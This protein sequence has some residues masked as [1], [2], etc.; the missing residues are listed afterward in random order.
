MLYLAKRGFENIAIACHDHLALEKWL[1]ENLNAQIEE[2]A[3]ISTH[4]SHNHSM[5]YLK[6]AAGFKKILVPHSAGFILSK[7]FSA[8]DLPAIE[9]VKVLPQ[10][11]F[12]NM[13]NTG[14]DTEAVINKVASEL[15]AQK[16]AIADAYEISEREGALVVFLNDSKNGQ[17]ITASNDLL[18]V[19]DNYAE[20]LSYLK[21]HA[22]RY[23]AK[24]Y[25]FDA[26]HIVE[27][28]IFDE[29]EKYSAQYR[30]FLQAM[31][32]LNLGYI[33]SEYWDREVER[34]SLPV[35]AYR[36]RILTFMEPMDFKILLTAL[37]YDLNGSR[38]VDLD[39]FY[40]QKKISWRDVINT[41]EYRKQI[42]GS[43]NQIFGKSSFF[44]E[45]SNKAAMVKYCTNK[46][47]SSLSQE[48][49]LL[50]K[51]WE[52]KINE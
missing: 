36:I 39:L 24:A 13:G 22:P 9:E 32:S 20:V 8:Q 43:A 37:E 16:I 46:L 27:V 6:T 3:F 34:F 41:K 17:Y 14:G 2:N 44:A 49:K 11:I 23:L 40:H 42:L 15:N 33:I 26:W 51:A 30:R 28:R 45:Q 47:M 31:Q 19:K 38:I 52:D 5:I 1:A 48:D 18:Y 25:P 35:G 12:M 29:R 7:M 10:S 50:F 21:I 4:D